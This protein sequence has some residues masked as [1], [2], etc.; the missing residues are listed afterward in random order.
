MPE[1]VK[2]SG[3]VRWDEDRSSCVVVLQGTLLGQSITLAT[4]QV[5]ERWNDIELQPKN[6]AIRAHMWRPFKQTRWLT[7]KEMREFMHLLDVDDTALLQIGCA[8]G[9]LDQWGK[10]IDANAV[11]R[12]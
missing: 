8:M 5:L 12:Q 1:L 4:F 10:E 3:F 11:L 9:W 7:F 2:Q 6:K